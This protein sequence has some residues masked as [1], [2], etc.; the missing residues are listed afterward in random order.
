MKEMMSTAEQSGRKEGR[1]G[2]SF[3]DTTR[4][5]LSSWRPV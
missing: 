5:D 4:H 3:F 1:K 2:G